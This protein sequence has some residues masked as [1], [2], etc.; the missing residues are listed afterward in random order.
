MWSVFLALAAAGGAADLVKIFSEWREVQKPRLV[1]GVPD[2]TPAA[3]A[4]QRD[5]LREREARLSALDVSSWPVS[6]QVDYQIVRAEMNGLDFDHRVLKPWERNP[7]FYVTV[8]ADESDQPAREGPHALGGVELFTFSLP[9]DADKLAKRLAHVPA[10]LQQARGNL[11]GDARDLWIYG[12]RGVKAQRAALTDLAAKASSHAA[13]TGAVQRAIEA[14]DAFVKWLEAQAPAKTGPSG[15]GI[16]NYDWYLANVQLVRYTWADEV[17]LMQ[18]ELARARSSLALEEAKNRALP[19]QTPV[20]SAEEHARRFGAAVTEYMTFLAQRDVLTIRKDM[21][22]ALRAHVG[23]YTGKRPLEFFTEVDYRDP[24]LMRTHGYHW[25]DLARMEDDPHPDPIRRG[26][27]LYNIFNTRTE[28]NATAMEEMMMQMGLC[29]SRPRSRE[30]V[31]VLLAQRAARALG[32]LRMHANQMSLEQ[33]AKFASE[34]TPRG[35]LRLSGETVWGEQHLYLQQPGYGTSYLIGKMELED[36]LSRKLAAG[37]TLR[38]FIDQRDAL[39]L[40]PV[41]LLRWEM[42]GDS[43]RVPPSTQR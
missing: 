36:I 25:F 31:Y 9:R 28:G 27:L 29:D 19:P 15:I 6:Q 34:N 7:D 33:A 41:S 32:E 24:V 10:L 17:L 23:Q 40:I 21:D 43:S 4:R 37:G 18:R 42:T 13:L 39:G 38:E 2:Y 20:A 35:W 14:T 5:E 26:A 11:T 22:P 12:I 8:F 16:G 3:M 30:L 1:N